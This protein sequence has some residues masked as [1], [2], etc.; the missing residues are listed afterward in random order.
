MRYRV[1][2]GGYELGTYEAESEETALDQCA[3][4]HGHSSY[5]A[6]LIESVKGD[7][8]RLWEVEESDPT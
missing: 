4:D 1:T 6:A 7:P 5:L 8:V 2:C 3:R